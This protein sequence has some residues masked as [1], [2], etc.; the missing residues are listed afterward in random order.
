MYLHEQLHWYVTWYSH[1]EPRSWG[2]LFRTLRENY[3]DVPPGAG[4][5]FSAYLHLIVN[6]LEIDAVS[7]FMDRDRVLVHVR[8]LP[9]YRWMYRTVVADWEPLSALYVKHGLLPLRYAT[10]MS[11]DELRWAAMP[12]EADVSADQPLRD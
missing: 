9:F 8:E 7:R 6:W 10:E 5:T 4:D 11:A 12:A 2:A 1:A 3:P